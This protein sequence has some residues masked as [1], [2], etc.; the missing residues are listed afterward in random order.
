MENVSNKGLPV[1]LGLTDKG[2]SYIVDLE[3]NP[4]SHIVGG[5][6]SC[7]NWLIY[8]LM[9]TLLTSNSPDDLQFIILDDTPNLSGK[10]FLKHR[11][12]GV[13]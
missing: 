2:D 1:L 5:T 9:Y 11:M 3:D 7:K 4:I 13:S 12:F 6:G 10:S 8:S